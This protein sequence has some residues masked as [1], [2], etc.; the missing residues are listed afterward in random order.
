MAAWL[1]FTPLDFHLWLLPGTLYW[2]LLIFNLGQGKMSI[3]KQI[4]PFSLKYWVF[5]GFFLL[6]S[7]SLSKCFCW[8]TAVS[9]QK[10]DTKFGFLLILGCLSLHF[11]AYTL[12]FPLLYLS[13]A[14]GLRRSR[15]KK[16]FQ[17]DVL[18]L[19]VQ[20][21]SHMWFSWLAALWLKPLF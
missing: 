16:G 21:C 2:F 3:M 10:R 15:K 14:L 6:A 7:S 20:L 13:K 18:L 12:H 19:K 1:T 9:A 5:L 8:V 11:E 4:H 17:R